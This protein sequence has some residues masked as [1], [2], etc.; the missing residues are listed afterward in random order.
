MMTL[1]PG[2]RKGKV[3][4][5]PSKSHAHRLL[6]ANFLAGLNGRSGTSDPTTPPGRG[7]SPS[8]PLESEDILA[9]KRC[10]SALNSQLSTLNS[11]PVLDCGESGST[12]RFLAPIAAALGVRPKWVMR[13]RLAERPF[14]PYES[15]APGV[16]T[17]A[18]DVSSQF[19]TGLL[20][21]LPLLKGDS[22]IR[23]TSPLESRGY[24]DM[25]LQVLKGAGIVVREMPDGFDI[26]GNQAYHPQSTPVEGDW[27]GAAFWFAMNAL[28]SQIEISGLNHESAQPDRAISCLKLPLPLQLPLN[29]SQFPDLFPALSVMAA[30]K[31]DETRFTGIRR[32]RL[33]E[34]DRVAAMADVLTRFGVKVEVSESAFTVQGTSAPFNGGEFTTYGDH[35]IAMAIAVGATRAASSVTLDNAAC[36]AKSYPAFFK[37]FTNVRRMHA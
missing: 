18:G 16:H 31:K 20:F 36:A 19:V 28:G 7:R 8:A 13:G 5:P 24:V 34:C 32:L 23:F 30:G 2:L 4:A 25:T 29:V 10:L 22:A 33:K 37:E 15:L 35:R 12:L 9:T 21:A 27:S 14:T 1:E 6:I 11:H 26:P 17:L 3:I